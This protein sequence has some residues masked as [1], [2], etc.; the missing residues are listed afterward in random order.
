MGK[1]NDDEI[2]EWEKVAQEEQMY[3]RIKPTTNLPKSVIN[4]I[5]RERNP[6]KTAIN[7]DDILNLQI[8]LGLA[9]KYTDL[10]NIVGCQEFG[11]NVKRTVDKSN[12]KALYRL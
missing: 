9:Q 7:A 3:S 2:P 5:D 12:S 6:N 11:R 4:A 8:E 10:L 1:E